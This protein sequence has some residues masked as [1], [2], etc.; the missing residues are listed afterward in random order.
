MK[1][2][3][4]LLFT[5]CLFS[6]PAKPF[7]EAEMR[8]Q[9]G[10]ELFIVATAYALALDHN[11]DVYL[12]ELALKYAYNYENLPLNLAHIFFRCNLSNPPGS[13]VCSWHQPTFGYHKI[14]FQPNMKIHGYFQSEKFFAHRRKDI[15]KLFAPHPEDL[16]YIHKK[17]KSILKHPCT[18]GIQLR[19]FWEDPT[20]SMFIQYGKDYLKKAMSFFPKNALF[21]LCSNDFEFVRQNIPEEMKDKVVC[22]ENE[23]HYIDLFI[24]SLC[25]HNIISNSSFGWWGAWLNENPEKLVIAPQHWVNPNGSLFTQDII[26]EKWIKLESKWGPL[27]DP[28]SYQ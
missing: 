5:T 18:V 23:P 1:F 8:G 22:I 10:N 14:S 16:K 27:K 25:K 13:S 4:F 7:I 2:F 19:K 11:A 6:A 24:L 28:S 26:P 9:L 17:Y 21:V 3:S 15:I 20:G 12:P